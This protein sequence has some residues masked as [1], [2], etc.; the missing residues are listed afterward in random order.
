MNA[1]VSNK[2]SSSAKPNEKVTL[3]V[4]GMGTRAV[5]IRVTIG[6]MARGG[7]MG[8][9]RGGMMRGRRGELKGEGRVD[10]GMGGG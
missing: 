7:I 8:I 1:S 5:T 2:P 3:S 9:R 10:I 4:Y 6:G